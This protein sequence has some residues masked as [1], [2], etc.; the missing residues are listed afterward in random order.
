MPVRSQS[1]IS[2]NILTKPV[3]GANRGI[4][5]GIAECCLDNDAAR[6][7]SLDIG[8]TTEDFQSLSQRFPDRLYAIHADVTQESSIT[9]A[10]DQ[11][12]AEA[13]A[14][15]G[16]VVNAGRTKHKP[17]LEFTDE[18]LEGLFAVNVLFSPMPV[19]GL[20]VLVLTVQLFGAFFTARTAARAF[21][22]LGIKGAIVF[23]ASMASYRPN[24]V[25]HPASQITD[26][27]LKTKSESPQPPTAPPKP[28]SA[29]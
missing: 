25:P 27:K 23:T 10:V 28:A 4:G 11:V 17:A 5:L 24:K 22:R 19:F 21:I 18:E 20:G 16:M 12:I 15:H 3:T 1:I 13:G 14:L 29:T 2:R 26:R 8:D 7:Y 9:A 6:V